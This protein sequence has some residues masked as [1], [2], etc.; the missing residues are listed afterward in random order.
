MNKNGINNKY[1]IF[2]IIFYNRI[3]FLFFFVFCFI[4]P[5]I[6]TF[7]Y[8]TA[9]NLLSG[10]ILLIT[11]EGI[12]KFDQDTQNQTLINE[13]DNFTDYED[14]KYISFLQSPAELGNYLF[15]RIKQ[16]IYIIS[17]NSYNLINIITQNEILNYEASIIFYRN[18]E[19]NNLLIVSYIDIETQINIIIYTNFDNDNINTFNVTKRIGYENDT[20]DYTISCQLMYSPLYS[21]DLLICFIGNDSNLLSGLVFD[22]ENNFSFLFTVT[23]NVESNGIFALKTIVS[24]DKTN[25]LICYE[26]KPVFAGYTFDCIRFN[27]IYKIWSDTYQFVGYSSGVQYSFDIYYINNNNEYF[28]YL[29]VT[30]KRYNIYKLDNEFN[31]KNS[32]NGKKCFLILTYDDGEIFYNFVILYN[33]NKYIKLNS[34]EHSNNIYYFEITEIP[35]NCTDSFY[36]EGFNLNE[37]LSSVTP[38][39]TPLTHKISS[40]NILL[41]NK[42]INIKLYNDGEIIKGVINE[43]KEN[44]VNNINEILKIIEIGYKYKIN[45]DEYNMTISPIE[46]INSF[47]S[48]YI[49]F[50]KCEEILRIKYNLPN[51]EILTIL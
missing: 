46:D 28:I 10:D 41:T 3:K 45:G 36:F 38:I 30:M 47:N 18:K 9:Y 43:P 48:S 33:K 51:E 11:D 26:N 42:K 37:K 49:D 44:I 15:C 23:N 5:K 12:I 13:I 32:N 21:N 16:Y 6:K 7:H 8:F 35:N 24:P 17:S 19:L 22:P 14:L 39:T 1:K 50:S 2:S 27:F 40:E 25:C 29:P 34:Y 4:I 20:S 31:I